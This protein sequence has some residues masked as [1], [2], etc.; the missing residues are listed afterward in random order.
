MRRVRK[1]DRF[2]QMPAIVAGPDRRW[3]IDGEPF[4]LPTDS[5]LP[6]VTERRM[7]R[8]RARARAQKPEWN[9]TSLC[10]RY[11]LTVNRLQTT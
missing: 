8:V 10:D 9:V 11:R 3:S 2:L 4:D 7:I 6:N 5:H 1:D